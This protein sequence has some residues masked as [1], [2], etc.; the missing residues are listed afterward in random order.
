M[1]AIVHA[2][3]QRG[4]EEIA[5]GQPRS[6]DIDH[7]ET[8]PGWPR[9]PSIARE[10]RLALGQATTLRTAQVLLDQWAGA[11]AHETEQVLQALSVGA[12]AEA[13][14]RLEAVLRWSPLGLHLVTP[15]RVVLAGRPNVGKSSLINALLGY[16]RSIVFDQPGTTRDV[17]TATAALDG[18]PVE[19]TD[20]A[21]V[22]QD[23]DDP[24]ADEL[25]TAGMAKA[26]DEIAAAD[27]LVLVFDA[28]RRRTDDE[29]ELARRWPS[30]VRVLSKCDLIPQGAADFP[31]FSVRESAQASCGRASERARELNHS[32]ATSPR[33]WFP[34]FRRLPQRCPLL[35]GKST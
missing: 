31:D 21:G 12:T 27:L 5:V 17:V 1:R 2:L 13:A 14:G 7:L 15:W 11:L 8:L 10:A 4:A 20:T 16:E 30:A 3:V 35:H 19:L 25:E 23:P 22:P 29:Q 34:M 32:D 9:A 33:G 28:S 18:W 24:S 6:T 26:W